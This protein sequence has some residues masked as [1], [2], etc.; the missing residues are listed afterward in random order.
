MELKE[1]MEA[2]FGEKEKEK[3]IERKR[4]QTLLII[5]AKRRY[6]A[7]VLTGCCHGRNQVCN[8]RNAER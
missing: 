3:Q 8:V 6:A 4:E 2:F 7:E 5:L 1:R